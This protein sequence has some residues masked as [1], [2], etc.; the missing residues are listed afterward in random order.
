MTPL[1]SPISLHA[2]HRCSNLVLVNLGWPIVFLLLISISNAR[3]SLLFCIFL[4]KKRKS[5]GT[6][7]GSSRPCYFPDE[8]RPSQS[9]LSGLVPFAGPYCS[10]IVGDCLGKL[11]HLW[12]G[13]SL[14]FPVSPLCGPWNLFFWASAC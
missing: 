3:F 1:S 4:G 2:G 5:W 9:R 6:Y 14:L 8:N 10:Q 13:K 12:R 11:R 7:Y